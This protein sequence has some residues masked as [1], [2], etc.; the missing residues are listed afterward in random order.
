MRNRQHTLLAGVAALALFAANGIALAQQNQ[1]EQKGAAQSNVQSQRGAQGTKNQAASQGLKNDGAQQNK[2]PECQKSECDVQA[3]L[4]QAILWAKCT[5]RKQNA[6]QADW[7]R[8]E[9]DRQEQCRQG[10]EVR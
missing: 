6:V 5:K 9:H 1:Q 10:R 3:I 4:W 2:K 8:S 7:R